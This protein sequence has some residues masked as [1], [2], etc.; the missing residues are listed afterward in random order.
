KVADH[1]EQRA[2][3]IAHRK[4][5]QIIAVILAL[6]GRWQLGP[7][8]LDLATPKRRSGVAIGDAFERHPESLAV[9]LHIGHAV[10]R[11]APRRTAQKP[12]FVAQQPVGRISEGLDLHA[13]ANAVGTQDAPQHNTVAA[14]ARVHGLLKLPAQAA[15]C[16]RWPAT[17]AR[18]RSES[19]AP[20][21]TQ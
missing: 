5:Q 6:A 11:L 3:G 8:H 21:P 9:R 15:A 10:G 17:R 2:T 19:W 14:F 16:L 20:C 13:A 7:L 18:T 4:S 1:P 12:A